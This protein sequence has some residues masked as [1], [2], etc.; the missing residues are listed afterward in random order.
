MISYY[1][2]PEKG[3]SLGKGLRRE[4]KGGR[5]RKFVGTKKVGSLL[6]MV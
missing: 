3:R 5:A 1:R 2:R 4:K 6:N